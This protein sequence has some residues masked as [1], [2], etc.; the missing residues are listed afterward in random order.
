MDI[1]TKELVIKRNATIFKELNIR[2]VQVMVLLKQLFTWQ[3]ENNNNVC[4]K[5]FQSKI[6][7]TQY[8]VTRQLYTRMSIFISFS[9]TES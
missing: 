9:L 1:N 2:C 5:Q 3:G 4:K 6:D 7:T 8:K